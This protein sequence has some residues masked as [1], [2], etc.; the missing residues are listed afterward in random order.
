M[1]MQTE[2]VVRMRTIG[3]I[4]LAALVWAP[5]AAFGQ[6]SLTTILRDGSSR[7]V[8]L[9]ADVTADNAG[10]GNPDTDP[11]DGG[12]DLLVTTSATAHTPSPSALTTYGVT[13]IGM[14]LALQRNAAT[15]NALV[16]CLGAYQNMASNPAIA[17]G[18]DPVFLFLMRRLTQDTTFADAARAKWDAAIQSLGNGDVEAAGRAIKQARIDQG[19]PDLYPWDMCWFVIS[20]TRLDHLFPGQGFALSASLL[21]QIV[22]NDLI[23]PSPTFDVTATNRDFYDLGLA[24]ALLSLRVTNI[25]PSQSNSLLTRLIA[26]QNPD[27]SWGFSDLQPTGNIQSTAYSIIACRLF[28]PNAAARTAREAASNYLAS[29]QAVNGGFPFDT[30]GMEVPEADSEALLAIFFV[31]PTAPFAPLVA[32]DLPEPTPVAVPLAIEIP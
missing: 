18:P 16:A 17:A 20:A 10:N 28:R 14:A 23:S 12:W 1:K 8:H 6:G 19:T 15:T 21:S 13:S 2:V 30:N 5:A 7:I 26:R 4:A 24:G 32:P 11:D 27:G 9:Q 22:L 29:I 25:S 31:P 3:S